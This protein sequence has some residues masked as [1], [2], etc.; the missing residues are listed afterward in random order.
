L[1][2]AR[3]ELDLAFALSASL[4]NLEWRSWLSGVPKKAKLFS[5]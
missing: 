1:F 3:Q 2:Q 4:M 5:E